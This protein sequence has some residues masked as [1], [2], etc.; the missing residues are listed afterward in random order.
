MIRRVQIRLFWQL[1]LF[2]VLAAKT[3]PPYIVVAAVMSMLAAQAV[4]WLMRLGLANPDARL[5]W[6]MILLCLPGQMLRDYGVVAGALQI[7]P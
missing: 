6:L 1:A 2:L 7:I 3:D 5:G 4:V